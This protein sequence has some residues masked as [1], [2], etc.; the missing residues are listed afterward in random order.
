MKLKA[1]LHKINL[2]LSEQDVH[3][4][5]PVYDPA[6]I[7]VMIAAVIMGIAVLFWLLWALMV[8]EG[9]IFTKIIPFLKVVCTSKTL[10]DFGYEGYPYEP[11]IFEGWIVNS[12]ALILCILLMIGIYRIFKKLEEKV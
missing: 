1:V 11:G 12:A 10:Q 5:D 9:G 3:P 2:F 8:C 7:A 4:D 6:H